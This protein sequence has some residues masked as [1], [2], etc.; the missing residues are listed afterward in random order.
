MTVGFL[1]NTC[2]PFYRGGYE[3]RAWNFARELAR[4]GHDVRIYTSCPRD[5]TIDGVHFIRLAPPRSYFNRRGVRNGWADLLFALSI[6]KLLGKL[7]A[8]GLDVLDICATPFLHLP[9][10]AFVIRIKSIP[11]VL[12]CHEAL[13]SS[14]PAYAQERGCQNP[15]WRWLIIQILALIYRA[16]TGLFANRLAVSRR[17][18]TALEKEG[19][20]AL[21]TVEF[22]LEPGAFNSNPPVAPAD[23]EPIRLIFCGRLTSIKN[24]SDTIAALTSPFFEKDQFRFDI[25]GQGSERP[26]LEDAVRKAGLEKS[27]IFHHDLSDP[28]KCD[29]LAHAE[30]FILSSPREGFSIATLEAM[31]QGCAALV[32]S[33]PQNPNGATDFVQNR[34]E[35]MVVPP[36]AAPLAAALAVLRDDAP[37]RLALRHAAWQAAQSYRIETQTRKLVEFYRQR[38]RNE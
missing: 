34:R 2:E 24:V 6:L 28:A 12:T 30:I 10:A 38:H 13:L 16:C 7:K 18:A 8:R 25:I 21:A 22:G 26:K 27:V 14:L 32:V 1:I 3:R 37:L 36:G 9:L 19:Y 5:E 35:G 23:N 11:A 4:Q 17:T 20:P 31:A 33:D 15:V 29:L